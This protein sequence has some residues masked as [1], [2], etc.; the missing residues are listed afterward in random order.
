MESRLAKARQ[1]SGIISQVMKKVDLFCTR[2]R[3]QFNPFLKDKLTSLVEWFGRNGGLVVKV[4]SKKWLYHELVY[5]SLLSQSVAL[6]QILAFVVK[7]VK[8]CPVTLY[9]S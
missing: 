5:I 9:S 6:I 3:C 7:L 1:L 8:P 4:A 2:A